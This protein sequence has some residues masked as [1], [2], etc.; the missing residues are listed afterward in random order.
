MIHYQ[1]APPQQTYYDQKPPMQQG[2]VVTIPPQQQVQGGVIQQDQQEARKD[3]FG[4]IGGQVSF[5]ISIRS[6]AERIASRSCKTRLSLVRV[7]LSGNH[8]H[9]GHH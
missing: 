7:S 9:R 5:R 1:P 6:S 4:K 3:Q 2:Q 8:Y